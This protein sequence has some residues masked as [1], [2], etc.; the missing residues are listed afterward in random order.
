MNPT[1]RNRRRTPQFESLEA[2][3]LLS[4]GLNLFGTTT[5]SNPSENDSDSVEVGVRF[6]SSLA[7][8]INGI[9]FYQS[10]ENTGTH[11]VDLW[12]NGGA[13]LASA[14][15]STDVA[16][17]H[18]IDFASPIAITPNTLYVASVHMPN[19]HYADDV[20]VFTSDY[21]SG[22]LQAPADTYD[23]PN[24]VYHY[25]GAQSFPDHGYQQSNYYV[26]VDFHPALTVDAVSPALDDTGVSRSTVVTATFD[27]ALDPDTLTT[28]TFTLKRPNGTLVSATVSYNS[29]TN[30]ATLTPNSTLDANTTYTVTLVG[31][32]NGLASA[33]GDKFPANA[34]WSFT[35]GS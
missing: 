11:V 6:Q 26:D 9:R 32:P 14:S 19:G 22:P 3:T 31:A 5:P 24:G 21:T 17:W 8:T 34:S 18:E 20:N 4:G 23:L 27:V 13:L 28:S 15:S 10:A 25:G 35:T 2:L 33:Y 29:T 12:T 16:G 7:G 1:R 30:T